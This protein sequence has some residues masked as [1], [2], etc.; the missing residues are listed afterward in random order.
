MPPASRWPASSRRTDSQSVP[1][2]TQ[3]KNGGGPV[4]LTAD[5]T[6]LPSVGPGDPESGQLLLALMLSKGRARHCSIASKPRK[7][8]G[9]FEKDPEIQAEKRD[10]IGQPGPG[11]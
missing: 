8:S 7:Y 4:C 9:Y 11:M 3:P 2:A 5:N 10:I 6:H 1:W